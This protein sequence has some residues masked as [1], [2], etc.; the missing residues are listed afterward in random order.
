MG[1]VKELDDRLHR[2]DLLRKPKPSKREIR[3]FVERARARR[4]LS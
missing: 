2:F 1:C 3:E 4:R